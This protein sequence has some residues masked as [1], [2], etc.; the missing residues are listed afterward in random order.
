M[1]RAIALEG[2]TYLALAL[3]SPIGEGQGTRDK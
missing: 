2:A 3:P 1:A